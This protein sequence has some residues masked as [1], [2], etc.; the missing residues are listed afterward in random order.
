MGALFPYLVSTVVCCHRATYDFRSRLSCNGFQTLISRQYESLWAQS[1]K[2]WHK[3]ASVC[4]KF[5]NLEYNMRCA[6]VAPKEHTSLFSC[7]SL[8]T[9]NLPNDPLFSLSTSLRFMLV[10]NWSSVALMACPVVCLSI[11]LSCRVS[12]SRALGPLGINEESV[13]LAKE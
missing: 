4:V 9:L 6:A 10:S 12:H 1:H 13:E 2:I 5:K 11:A 3:L 7:F 8:S